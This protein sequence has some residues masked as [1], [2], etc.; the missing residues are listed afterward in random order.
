MNSSSVNLLDAVIGDAC[1]ALFEAVGARLE[2]SDAHT[3]TADDVGASI[4][5]TGPALR[6]A[7]V[8]ISTHRFVQRVLPAEIEAGDSAEQVADWT[9][10]LANQLLGRIKNKLLTYGVTLEMSTPTVIFGLELIRKSS[11]S[12]ICRQFSFRQ[13]EDAL[14]IYFDAVAAPGF[15]L[16]PPTEPPEP[17][18][19]E[20][21]LA[22][23]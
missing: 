5:F 20:G 1:R 8:M 9:G 16:T 22:L 10:E 11:R 21:E 19:A 18:I 3:G 12:S 6:G 23:F 7:L 13:G 14:S 2:P 15:E 4:G 17:G